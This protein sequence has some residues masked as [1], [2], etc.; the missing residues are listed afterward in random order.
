MKILNIFLFY[1]LFCSAVLVY[2]V[3]TL[4][5]AESSLSRKKILLPAVKAFICVIATVTLTFLLNSLLLSSLGLTEIYPLAALL[6]FIAFGTFFEIILEITAKKSAAEFAVS[7]LTV[8]LAL[9]EGSSLIESIAVSAGC[10]L[11]YYLLVPVLFSFIRKMGEAKNTD[12]FK[13]KTSVFLCMM[14]LMFA[15]YALNIS[16]INVSV[17]R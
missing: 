10:L 1:I 11:S 7:Y 13:Q 17:V 4:Q 12:S 15:L 9:N 3:G 14:I 16:W 2:G 5:S 6:I 8:L